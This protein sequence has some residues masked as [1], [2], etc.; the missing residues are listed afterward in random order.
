MDSRV[1]IISINTR[2]TFKNYEKIIEEISEFDVI[3]L[4]EQCI[5][6]RQNIIEKYEKDTGCKAYF[7]IDN[8]NNKSIITLVN[9]NI[10]V[11]E[12]RNS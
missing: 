11:L 4:Q 6:K 8:E 2:G 7:T 5:D 3:L 1:K 10:S 9:K 12:E